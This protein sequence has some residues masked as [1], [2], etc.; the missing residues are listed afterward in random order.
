M[1]AYDLMGEKKRKSRRREYLR[2]FFWKEA[3]WFFFSMKG[4]MNP[5]GNR[6][7]NGSAGER[8]ISK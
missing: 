5:V 1:R 7:L 8:R 6:E 4:R 2:L 3:L